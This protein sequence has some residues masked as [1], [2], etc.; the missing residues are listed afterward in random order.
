M[1]QAFSHASQ[2]ETPGH[3][4][5]FGSSLSSSLAVACHRNS[6]LTI[7]T[8]KLS[9]LKP[10]SARVMDLK[11]VLSLAPSVIYRGKRNDTMSPREKQILQEVSSER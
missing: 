9:A 7:S 6:H 2:S 1:R 4:E 3:L 10:M 5:Q 8:E 11:C